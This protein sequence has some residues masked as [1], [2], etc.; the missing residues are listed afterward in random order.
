VAQKKAKTPQL[1]QVSATTGDIH[2]NGTVQFVWHNVLSSGAV[3][4]DHFAT[5]TIEYGSASAW[6]ASWIPA[7]HLVQ[8]RIEALERLAERGVVNR[9]SRNMAYSLFANNLVDYAPKYRGMQAVMLHGLEACADITLS[10][11]KGGTWTV[12]P[13]FIDSVAHLAGFVMN[14]SDAMDTKANFCVTPGWGSMRFARP[15]LADKRYKSYVKMIATAEDPDI[16]LG[17]VYVLQ[18]GEVIGFVG[19]IKFRRYPRLLLSRFFTAPDEGG[20]GTKAGIV[21]HTP[22]AVTTSAKPAA[23]PTPSQAGLKPD[24]ILQP[25]VLK[26]PQSSKL[27]IPSPQAP[28]VEPGPNAALTADSDST[29]A[30]AIALVAAEAGLEVADLHDATGFAELGVDSLMSLVIAE[31]FR[32]ELEV[33]V[34]GSLFLEYPTVGDLK[35][36]LVEYYG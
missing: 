33:I 4:D 19:G 9:L 26:E 18:G 13:Y 6:L 1:I 16:Y 29:A 12:P 5:A 2:G 10:T 21:D 28:T 22:A 36:W 35:S 23:V 24:A 8:G 14:V 17:D 25:V 31:K 34:S 30:K 20:P 7:A 27:A 15:L 3:A 32:E 11:E